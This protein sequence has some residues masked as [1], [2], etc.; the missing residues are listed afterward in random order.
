MQGQG[1]R[2]LPAVHNPIPGEQVQSHT[3]Y[4]ILRLEAH[5]LSRAPAHCYC[6]AAVAF[7]GAAAVSLGAA[8]ASVLTFTCD[9]R[10]VKI[11]SQVISRSTSH[12]LFSSA[13][14]PHHTQGTWLTTPS[15]VTLRCDDPL[16]QGCHGST[17]TRWQ[18]LAS[19]GENP[20]RT[21]KKNMCTK[22]VKD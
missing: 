19:K 17:T 12:T 3:P 15:D 11:S 6:T 16:S 4:H 1:T 5:T 22:D 7:L 21:H 14:W 20:Q 2:W 18:P 9:V 10:A 13:Q 8:A